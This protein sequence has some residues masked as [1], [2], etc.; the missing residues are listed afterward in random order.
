M[1]LNFINTFNVILV[2]VDASVPVVNSSSALE[3]LEHRVAMLELRSSLQQQ[4]QLLLLLLK[5]LIIRRSRN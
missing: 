5:G 1:I 4:Q 2:G 3:S